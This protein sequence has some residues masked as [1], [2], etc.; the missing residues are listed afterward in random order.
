MFLSTAPA[1]GKEYLIEHMRVDLS[2]KLPLIQSPVLAIAALN[3]LGA[4]ANVFPDDIK[5]MWEAC[6]DKAKGTA[7]DRFRIVYFQDTGQFITEERPEK[8]DQ[9]IAEF[10]D[11]K[12]GTRDQKQGTR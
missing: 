8:L 12:Q 3:N 10:L 1:V 9:T 11:Q 6:F 5:H 2:D 4:G 7:P